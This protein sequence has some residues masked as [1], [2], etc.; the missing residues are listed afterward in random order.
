M[1]R[2]PPSPFGRGKGE[3]QRHVGDPH[4]YSFDFAQDKL[5][6]RGRGGKK[7]FL[8]ECKKS[9]AEARLPC[10]AGDLTLAAS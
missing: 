5:S 3:G 1:I 8:G 6:P 9:G 2:I 7:V 10:S 4:L